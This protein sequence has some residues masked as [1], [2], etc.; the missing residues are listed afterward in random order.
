[1]VDDSP[2][3]IPESPRDLH[4][5]LAHDWLVGMRGG[6]RVLERLAARFGPC[7]LHVMVA[8][9]R[10]H[11]PAIDACRLHTSSLQRVPGAAGRLRRWLLPLYPR[12]VESLRVDPR[13]DLLI[14]SSSALI[15]G[16]R[17]PERARHI[18]Y[19]HAPPRY[20]WSI[21][22][23]YD[24]ES[25]IARLRGLGLRRFRTRLCDWDRDAARRI[26]AFIANSTAT[27]DDIRRC[28]DRDSTVI[29][30]P[31]RTDYFTPGDDQRDDFFLVVSALEPY[32]RI[33]LAI[34]AAHRCDVPL[35]IVGSGSQAQTLRALGNGRT[36]FLGRLP[37]EQVR[38]LYRRARAL[39]FPGRE[40]F[41]IAPVEAMACGC[42]VIAYA[43]GGASDWMRPGCGMAVSE[44]TVDAFADAISA[45]RSGDVSWSAQQCRDNALRFS[46]ARFDRELAAFIDD[47]LRR[48][49]AG[50]SGSSVPHP[51]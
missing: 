13:T 48:E 23:Q 22:D 49:A 10:S 26:D 12:A 15:K 32:K 19:C 4:V 11:G 18:C 20:L 16:I 51:A 30:P 9:G 31:V 7:D 2:R 33:D 35:R 24:G 50:Q 17:L 40:D 42:P 38:S 43:Q 45:F 39:L 27:A 3:A 25:L 46:E 5:A 36:A 44:Q 34:A 37:D 28:Y 41:G 8:D 21:P 47:F 14:S 29:H 1:M 6:E